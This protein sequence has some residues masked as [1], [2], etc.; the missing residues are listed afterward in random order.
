MNQGHCHP[1]SMFLAVVIAPIPG[2]LLSSS[3]YFPFWLT[4]MPIQCFIF[5]YI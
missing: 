2:R 4:S 5:H 1:W 3:A